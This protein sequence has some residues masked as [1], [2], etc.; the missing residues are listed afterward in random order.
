M[1]G[2]ELIRKVTKLGRKKGDHVYVNADRG[3]GG[4]QT[5][6]YNDRHSVI[7]T[8]EIRKGLLYRI[9][10]QLNINPKEL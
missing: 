1:N 4:H 10:K 9:C 8:G 3:K 7:P 5:L 6:Y 2:K